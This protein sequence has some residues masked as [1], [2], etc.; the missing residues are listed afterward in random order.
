VLLYTQYFDYYT[1]DV[2]RINADGTG[3]ANLTVGFSRDLNPAWSPDG[4]RIAFV[5]DR[6]HND[7][8]HLDASDV[9]LMQADGTGPVRV[10]ADVIAEEDVEWSP[11]GT[12][13]IFQQ[14]FYEPVLFTVAAP[15]PPVDE[16]AVLA[17]GTPVRVGAGGSPSWQPVAGTPTCTITGTS[18]N[19]TLKGTS[20]VDVIC[21]LGGNDTLQGGAGADT[22]I[23]GKGND[24]LAGG[25][26]ADRLSGGAGNDVCDNI[27]DVSPATSCTVR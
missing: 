13:V 22:L 24:R 2:W 9:Y 19:D 14:G 10:T 8:F 20:G 16:A 3:A 11:D 15:P 1:T 21:G 23:G 27:G 5:S 25:R 7:P 18:G 6:D 12:Q 26:G 4:T 17:I